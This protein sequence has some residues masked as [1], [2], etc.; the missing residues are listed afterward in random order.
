MALNYSKKT[1]SHTKLSLSGFICAFFCH[2]L[3]PQREG[4]WGRGGFMSKPER[5]I[6]DIFQIRNSTRE[7]SLS[8]NSLKAADISSM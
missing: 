4:F 3:A 8:R 1:V 2:Y 7:Q 6:W 5:E